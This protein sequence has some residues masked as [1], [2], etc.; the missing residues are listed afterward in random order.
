VYCSQYSGQPY[1]DYYSFWPYGTVNSTLAPYPCS[2]TLLKAHAAAVRSYRQ[3]VSSG[4][5]TKGE[6]AFKNDDSYPLPQD[7]NDPE[8]ARAAKR[9]FE[10]YIGIFSQPSYV[11]GKYPDVVRATIPE[12]F[13][14]N[15]TAE[16]GLMGTV[17]FYASKRLPGLSKL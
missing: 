14:P 16:D 10:F 5:I 12:A 7:E 17:D 15:L 1:T 9:H 2:Y 8:D 4:S 11:D 13:L 6:I 3:L